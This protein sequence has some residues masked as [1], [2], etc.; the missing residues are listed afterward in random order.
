VV[1]AIFALLLLAGASVYSWARFKKEPDD[2]PYRLFVEAAADITRLWRERFHSPL[3]IVV[4][5]FEVAAPIVFYSS[6]HPKM[7]ADFD[8][9]YSPWI[10]Y[11]AELRRK[12]I[13]RRLL[14]RRRELPGLSQIIESECRADRYRV[15]AANVRD[16]DAAHDATFG[17]HWPKPL[18]LAAGAGHEG[19]GF[20]FFIAELNTSQGDF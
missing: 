10:D 18:K 9:A 15:A 17:I 1:A 19:G 20:G 8:P 14:R 11:P 7:F 12:R 2:G 3:P 16:S 6:D 5:G 13:C 4:S